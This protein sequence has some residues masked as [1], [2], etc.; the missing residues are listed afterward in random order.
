[1]NRERRTTRRIDTVLPARC[2][3]TTR[4]DQKAIALDISQTGAQIL[5]NTNHCSQE[6][7]RLEIQLDEDSLLS[8]EGTRMWC[9]T[10]DPDNAL[11]GVKFKELPPSQQ[12]YLDNWVR[13]QQVS[14]HDQDLI[15]PHSFEF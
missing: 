5:L 13:D 3:T 11:M 7:V 9:T 15:H 4:A 1:M 8:V 6:H 12:R 10:L 14:V 2:R